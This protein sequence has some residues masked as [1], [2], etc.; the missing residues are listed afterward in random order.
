MSFTLYKPL[1]ANYVD[2]KNVY[3]QASAEF[4]TKYYTALDNNIRSLGDA[5][6]PNSQFTFV[7]NE[8]VGYNTFLNLLDRLG[9]NRMSHNEM[10]I[11]SQPLGSSHMLVN[12]TGA[13]GFN[14]MPFYAK[15]TET[16]FIEKI[17]KDGENKLKVCSSIFK[18]L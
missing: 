3:K 9:I 16:L 8:V 15:F 5:Y 6:Y 2:L 12:V 4:C 10:N 11:V 7:D 13:V 14:N 1:I 18:L 17:E